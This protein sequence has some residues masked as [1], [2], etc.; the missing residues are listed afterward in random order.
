[1]KTLLHVLFLFL[2]VTFLFPPVNAQINNIQSP[3]TLSPDQ[4]KGLTPEKFMDI[5]LEKNEQGV[6][7]NHTVGKTLDGYIFSSFTYQLWTGA[8]WENYFRYTFTYT[9]SFDYSEFLI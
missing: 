5:L 7:A 2:M 8:A 4:L 6:L 3:I 9:A 1:M